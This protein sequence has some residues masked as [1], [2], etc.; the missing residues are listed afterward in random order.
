MYAQKINGWQKQ[1]GKTC[2][3]PVGWIRRW[4]AEDKQRLMP[5]RQVPSYD[6]DAFEQYARNYQ[7]DPK[8]KASD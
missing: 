7:F 3:D 6:I 5:K 4:W 8:R 2:R 1:T